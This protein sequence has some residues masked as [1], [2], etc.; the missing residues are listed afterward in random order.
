MLTQTERKEKEEKVNDLITRAEDVLNV[1]KE[2]KRE[3][4][5]A[6]AQELAEIRDDVRKI[7]EFLKL[8]DDFKELEEMKVKKDVP[9]EEE[10]MTE[11]TMKEKEI[12]E[13][14]AFENFL[15][16]W[17]VHER[18]GELTPATDGT[19]GNGGV[20]IPQTIVNYIIKK[21]YNI[22]PILERSQKYNVKGK[23]EVPYYPADSTYGITVAYKSEFSAL[24]STA[25]NF[26]TVELTGYLAGCMT[27]ISRSLINNTQFD[28]VGF[29]VDEMAYAI[30]RFIEGEL[31]NGTDSKVAGLS[32]ATNSVTAAAQNAITADEIIKLHDKILDDYQSNAIWIMSPATRT[33]LRLLKDSMGRYLL[34]DDITSPFGSVLLGKPVYVSDH[35]PDMAHSA[36][37]IFYGDMHGLGTKFNEDINIEVLRERFADEHAVGVVGWF[38]FDAKVINQQQIAVLVMA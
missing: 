2:E 10:E 33:A 23:L 15:R 37:A 12:Q 34:Q 14:R 9:K 29:V 17:E 22:C 5:D 13:V 1:A 11:E 32:G 20:L 26:A 38:E 3:L 35:M 6:E 16:G 21:L 28:I 19:S 7:K 25:G 4:T 24:S 31:L 30:K 36:R 27:K 18:S 8:D